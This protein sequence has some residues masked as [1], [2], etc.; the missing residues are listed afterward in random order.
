MLSLSRNA[1]NRYAI[2]RERFDR[3]LV[4]SDSNAVLCPDLAVLLRQSV[5]LSRIRYAF[6]K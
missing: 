5:R 1:P 3:S 4:V 6:S 2:A